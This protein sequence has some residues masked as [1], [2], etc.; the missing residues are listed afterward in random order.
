MNYLTF[1]K[2]F[3]NFPL[4]DI[5]DVFTVFPGFDRRRIS[6]WREKG[7]LKKVANNFYVFADQ[8]LDERKLFFIANK[9]YEPSYVSL[10]TALG[11]HGLIPEGVFSIFS[12]STLKTRT[13]SARLNAIETN[14]SYKRIKKEFF[15]GY[16]LVKD[17]GVS[18]LV[19]DPEKAVLDFLYL[20]E[21]LKT[22]GDFF[23]LR[24]NPESAGK[25]LNSRKMTKYLAISNSRILEE[26]IR[27]LRK[28]YA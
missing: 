16:S 26:K 4:V 25:V 12:V 22:E 27:I 19:A 17:G 28:V 23:E 20:R 15:F 13:V 2:R 1:Q 9:I 21:D 6:E 10:E 18:F 5:R 24:L 11:Y 8:A 14:F 3:G 7:Y